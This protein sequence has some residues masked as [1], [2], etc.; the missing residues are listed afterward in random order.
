MTDK[1]VLFIDFCNYEDY[2]IGGH[3]TLAKYMMSGFGNQLSLV[4]ITTNKGDSVGKWIKREINGITFDFFPLARYDKSVTKHLV[5]DRIACFLLLLYYKREILKREYKNVF[6]QRPEVLPAIE[7]FGYEN[8]CYCFPGTENPLRTSKYSLAGFLAPLFD[9]VFFKSLRKTRLI[10]AS[11]DEEAILGMTKRSKGVISRERVIKFPTRI[12]TD[13]FKPGN[14]ESARDMLNLPRH[15]LLITTVGRLSWLKGWKLML[16]SFQLFLNKFPD[17]HFYFIGDGEDKKPIQDYIKRN[18]LS[19]RVDILG[20]KTPEEVALYLNSSDLFVMGSYKE[21][22]STTLMEAIACGIPVCV[23]NFSSASEMV[24]DGMN[25]F[26]VK[27]WDPDEFSGSMTQAIKMEYRGSDISNFSV[28][29]LK[30]D[31]LKYWDLV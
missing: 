16:D 21:G 23:T 29:A 4:G 11:A 17:S 9:R 5:P 18:D 24:R 31:I 8:I 6:V 22:W 3:L 12:D 20:M 27:N 14:K 10:L 2:Q 26:V 7:S 13:I 19:E 25:G 30:N 15:K 1:S 28:S